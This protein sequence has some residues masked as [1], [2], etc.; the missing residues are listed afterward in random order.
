MTVAHITEGIIPTNGHPCE[1]VWPENGRSPRKAAVSRV[2]DK[3]QWGLL[4]VADYM[5]SV[6]VARNQ[7]DNTRHRIKSKWS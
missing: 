2:P 6:A 5:E 4:E 1:E 3:I 7:Q